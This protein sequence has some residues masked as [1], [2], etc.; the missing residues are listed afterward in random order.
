MG[1][2]ARRHCIQALDGLGRPSYETLRHMAEP[3][4]S[5]A[6]LQLQDFG[7]MLAFDPTNFRRA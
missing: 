2:Q 5:G 7:F 3:C 4:G 6:N 1:F